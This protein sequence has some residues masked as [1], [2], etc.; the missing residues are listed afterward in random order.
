MNRHDVALLR[1]SG[2]AYD[3]GALDAS[4]MQVVVDFQRLLTKLSRAVYSSG[5]RLSYPS[6]KLFALDRLTI[7]QINP[8]NAQIKVQIIEEPGNPNS[9]YVPDELKQAVMMMYETY[10]AADKDKRL[11]SALPVDL[12]PRPAMVRSHLKSECSLAFSPPDKEL[13][14]ISNKACDTLRNWVK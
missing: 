10:A 14:P 7:S 9:R 4:A 8:Q 6:S 11:P 1:F 12:I 13:Q 5:Q 3:E 2:D